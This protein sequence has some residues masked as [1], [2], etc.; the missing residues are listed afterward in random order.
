MVAATKRSLSEFLESDELFVEAERDEMITVIHSKLDQ[1][2]KDVE[3]LGVELAGT[4]QELAGTEHKLA[5]IEQRLAGTEQRLAESQHAS[6]QFRQ[7]AR[8]HNSAM[9]SSISE[10]DSSPRSEEMF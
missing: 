10:T 7:Q 8:A 5:G 4:K 3:K 6:D 9:V 2:R 1:L